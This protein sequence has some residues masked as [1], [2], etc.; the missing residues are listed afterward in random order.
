MATQTPEQKAKAAADKKAADL[1]AKADKKAA[2]A[3]AKADKKATEA[4]AKAENS[5][6]LNATQLRQQKANELR[7]ANTAKA[8]KAAKATEAK[9][10]ED[11]PTS[12]KVAEKDNRKVFK[13]DRG[14]SFRFK[15]SAPKA[16]NIDGVSR[17]TSDLIEDEEVMLELVNGNSNFIEQ[18]Y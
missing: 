3:K 5:P 18:I 13:D 15:Q 16:L 12:K 11:N 10:T 14:L 7:K 6:V 8:E 17:K 1:K 9:K 2:D 4:K